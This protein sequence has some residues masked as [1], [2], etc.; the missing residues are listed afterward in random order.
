ME[1]RTLK[2]TIR[3]QCPGAYRLWCRLRYP[4]AWTIRSDLSGHLRILGRRIL[5]LLHLDHRNPSMAAIK[6]L[7]NRHL[8]ERCFIVGTG[9][10]LTYED[11]EKLKGETTF[12]MNS[13]FLTYKN[14]DWRPT[15]YA[16]VDYYGY[17]NDLKQYIG[18]NLGTYCLREVFLHYKIRPGALSGKEIYFLI[19]HGN[20][21]SRRIRKKHFKQEAEIS[22]CIYDCF[23]VANMVLDIALYMGFQE[24]YLIGIDCSYEQDKKHI[25]ETPAD[26]RR[27]TDPD[28]LLPRIDLMKEGYNVLKKMAEK[29]GAVI[30]NATR[31]GNLDVFPRINFDDII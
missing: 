16:I 31:G 6:A 24:I 29:Q 30:Y 18:E 8:G 28:Y 26:V 14:T 25:E 12:S 21:R 15:Y 4:Q 5:K 17:E 2:Q 11:L 1:A 10:S 23:T 9:A 13:I 19:H 22:I 20:H 27:R 7:K 3:D